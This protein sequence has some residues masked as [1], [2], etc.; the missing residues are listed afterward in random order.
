MHGREDPRFTKRK[1]QG[2]PHSLTMRRRPKQRRAFPFRDRADGMHRLRCSCGGERVIFHVD[3]DEVVAR[4][5]N[6]GCCQG[7][8]EAHEDAE[9]GIVVG[10]EG[11]KGAMFAMK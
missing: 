1:G 8:V 2:Q 10:S 4:R 7:I 5:G 3:D 11:M 9:L 6:D